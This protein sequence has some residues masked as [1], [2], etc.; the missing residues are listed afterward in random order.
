MQPRSLAFRLTV[1][2][3]VVAC[4]MLL[5]AA[6]L[7]NELFQRAV[8]RNFDQRLRAVMDSVLGAVEL[9]ED[10]T[11]KLPQPLA[12]PR[13]TIPLSG[14]YWQITALET[15]P[16]KQ[17]ASASLLEKRLAV[18]APA[19]AS[20]TGNG[21][22][23]FYLQDSNSR[24]LRAIEQRFELFDSGK[25]YSFLVAGDFDELQ[26]EVGAF[27]TLLY[28]VLGLLGLGL[29][30]AILVQVKFGLRPMQLMVQ[31]LNDI[32][33]GKSA[34][35]DG[36]FPTEMQPLADEINLL[37]KSNATIVDRAR[38]QVG[39]L[40]HALKTPLAVLT[41]EAANKSTA[42]SGLVEQ[43]TN[44][45]REQIDLYLDRARRA[46]RARNI[47]LSCDVEPV[48]QGL[49]RTLQ[50][51]NRDK[52]IEIAVTVSPGLKFRGD[53]QDLEEI[54]GNLID[55]A[56][57]WAKGKV[58]IN[59]YVEPSSTGARRQLAIVVEDDGPGIPSD[60]RATALKRG[61]RLDETKPG[62]GLGLN[63]VEETTA[64][65]DGSLSLDESSLGGLR[66]YVRLPAV[67]N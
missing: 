59:A 39:N 9:S 35:L 45:M 22:A 29:L 28:S 61:Q 19:L 41:N 55:N 11:P 31:K 23:E 54:A 62:S 57:K 33:S 49:A 63:I 24:Q 40:A 13:F 6:L 8:E 21:L 15:T 25:D 66:A 53:Q 60:H 65:Y 64:I 2:S 32:R 3:A 34:A 5:A 10:G 7:L 18:P 58:H 26:A 16:L 50:R 12:D 56:C 38:M 52:T 1:S 36:A 27:R 4:V 67:P 30:T 20:R 47:G 48:L 14:W 37:M 42:F 46:T 51:I 43:Q 44:N 17:L